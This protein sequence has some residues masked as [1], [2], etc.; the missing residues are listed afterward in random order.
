MEIGN[1]DRLA[2]TTPPVCGRIDRGGIHRFCKAHAGAGRLTPGRFS[3]ARIASRRWLRL[4]QRTHRVG[5]FR[6]HLADPAVWIRLVLRRGCLIVVHVLRVQFGSRWRGGRP[7]RLLAVPLVLLPSFFHPPG[8]FHRCVSWAA[9][10][11]HN[12]TKVCNLRAA[13]TTVRGLGRDRAKPSIG[14][15]ARP[16]SDARLSY[17]ACDQSP[18][19]ICGQSGQARLQTAESRRT[20]SQPAAEPPLHWVKAD[21]TGQGPGLGPGHDRGWCQ[22]VLPVSKVCMPTSVGTSER[23]SRQ[24][25]DLARTERADRSHRESS[26]R[27]NTFLMPTRPVLTPFLRDP[28]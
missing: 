20:E 17:L 13:L 25:L 14:A 12:L 27:L 9:N 6:P 10:N 26:G 11:D 16:E 18:P 7:Q 2:R 28:G 1:P 4:G 5:A 24:A 3:T 15:Q 8:L 21:A 19:L 23:L 22:S